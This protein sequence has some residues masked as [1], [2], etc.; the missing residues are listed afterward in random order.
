MEA[1]IVQDVQEI[2]EKVAA[3]IQPPDHFKFRWMQEVTVDGKPVYHL[4][5]E[6]ARSPVPALCGEHYSVLV[7][8]EGQLQGEILMD[9]TLAE[10][11]ALAGLPTEEAARAVALRYL[12]ERAPDLVAPIEIHWVAAHAEKVLL[13]SN[14][15]AGGLA[16]T[17]SGMKVKCRNKADGRW[18]W[19]IVGPGERVITF[20]R[21]VVW[22]TKNSMRQSEM[23]LHDLWLVRRGRGFNGRLIAAGE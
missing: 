6:P 15:V 14:E 16:V 22:N 11:I 21:D 10:E 7:T 13:T 1:G 19:V 17:V 3:Q 20:E 2:P 18:F 12:R 5:C 9:A 23:W 8:P 4:R